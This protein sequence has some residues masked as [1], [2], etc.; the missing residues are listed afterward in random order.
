MSIEKKLKALEQLTSDNLF[1]DIIN[2]GTDEDFSKFVKISKFNIGNYFNDTVQINPNVD[3]FRNTYKVDPDSGKT[4]LSICIERG[5]EDSAIL[6]IKMFEN[7]SR[8]DNKENPH[9]KICYEDSVWRDW[10]KIEE[11][12]F[13]AVKNERKKILNFMFDRGYRLNDPHYE[14]LLKNSQDD[15]F[16]FI[17]EKEVLSYYHF[18]SNGGMT[19]DKKESLCEKLF[20]I[21]VEN[22]ED[23]KIRF[24]LKKI[25]EN[26][27]VEKDVKMLY[28]NILIS[29]LDADKSDRHV[30]E[31]IKI[32]DLEKIRISEGLSDPKVE[33]VECLLKSKKFKQ[34]KRLVFNGFPLNHKNK[35]G[36]NI[37][38]QIDDMTF[39]KDNPIL[40]DI[41]K[42]VQCEI[43]KETLN[44]VF[45]KNI[46][47]PNQKRL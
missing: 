11:P 6:M 45:N 10:Y 35:N 24:R 33:I 9:F 2:N 36:L 12:I 16:D 30:K 7:R 5:L 13:T 38:E 4:A 18:A 32:V 3:R 20:N 42:I 37:I 34:L 14:Y 23:E 22:P 17:M 39:I 15:F 40:E 44:K 27:Y 41:K 1:W 29:M 19:S 26:G 47:S 21:I 31:L 43:E 8:S 28:E 25:I 46:K